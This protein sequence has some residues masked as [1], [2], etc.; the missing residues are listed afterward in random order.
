MPAAS[1]PRREEIIS[2]TDV[3]EARYATLQAAARL[4]GLSP[5]SLLRLS[6]IDASFPKFIRITERKRLLV[7]RDLFEWIAGRRDKEPLPPLR[8]AVEKRAAP[9]VAKKRAKGRR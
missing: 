8:P 6:Q 3:S 7:V 1:A 5:V 9:S 2:R 4:T